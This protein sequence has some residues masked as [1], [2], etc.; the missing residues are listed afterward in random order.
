MTDLETIIDDPDFALK[1]LL[2]DF[3]EAIGTRAET[4]KVWFKGWQFSRCVDTFV[5]TKDTVV[6]FDCDTYQKM[7]DFLTI[8]DRRTGRT[9]YVTGLEKLTKE[10]LNLT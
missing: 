2:T 8:R 6:N 4:V 5:F 7:R 3:A 10:K 1:V 9:D